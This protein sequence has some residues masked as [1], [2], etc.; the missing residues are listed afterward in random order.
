MWVCSE[1][2]EG[3]LRCGLH[4]QRGQGLTQARMI[5]MFNRQAEIL[6]CGDRAIQG[7]VY[8]LLV[9]LLKLGIFAHRNLLLLAHWECSGYL[10]NGVPDS[11]SGWSSL[12]ASTASLSEPPGGCADARR[13]MLLRKVSRICGVGALANA[14]GLLRTL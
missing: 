14:D 1:E 10:L 2:G 8:R 5:E 11:S 9:L 12:F 6:K 3:V 7:H 4:K 13:A